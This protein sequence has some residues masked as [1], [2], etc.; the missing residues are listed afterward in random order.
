MVL[1]KADTQKYINS[2]STQPAK[3][4]Y[5]SRLILLLFMKKVSTFACHNS[6]NPNK[7]NHLCLVEKFS[8]NPRS[9]K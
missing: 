7:F 9:V 5:S 6:D 2:D 3:K 4:L 1:L 8:G